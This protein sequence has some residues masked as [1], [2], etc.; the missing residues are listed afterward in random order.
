MSL[1][2]SEVGPIQGPDHLDY[3]GLADY[4][5]RRHSRE[6]GWHTQGTSE[7]FGELAG[8]R[9]WFETRFGPIARGPDSFRFWTGYWDQYAPSHMEDGR[10]WLQDFPHR[11]TWVDGV[12]VA[13]CVAAP[14]MGGHNVCR[15]GDTW[16]EHEP[17]VGL[18]IQ[19]PG[20]V[21]HGVTPVGGPAPRMVV[22]GTV[23]T[24]PGLINDPGRPL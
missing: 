5:D 8:F 13:L 2:P 12:T 20:T 23:F 19:M 16:L 11:H 14:E 3:Q 6:G 24:V 10:A 15:L 7:T 9:T 21:E 4:I 1:S 18:A 17:K 22:I